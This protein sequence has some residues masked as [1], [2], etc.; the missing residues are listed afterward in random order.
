MKKPNVTEKGLGGKLTALAV[1]WIAQPPE[2]RGAY[3]ER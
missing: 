3:A 2:G 1:G